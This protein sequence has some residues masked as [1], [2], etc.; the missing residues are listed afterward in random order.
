MTVIV[1]WLTAAS[2]DAVT[3]SQ[4]EPDEASVPVGGRERAPNM[5]LAAQPFPRLSATTNLGI[6]VQRIKDFFR[7][8]TTNFYRE[9]ALVL[10]RRLLVPQTTGVDRVFGFQWFRWSQVNRL[11]LRLATDRQHQ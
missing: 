1:G 8:L 10:G 4:I 5:A 3:C 6:R 9:L 7:P 2:G 11:F